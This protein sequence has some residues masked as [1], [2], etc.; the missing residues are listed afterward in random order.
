MLCISSSRIS[1]TAVL[2]LTATLAACSG[3]NSGNTDA[4]PVTVQSA[5]NAD[6]TP[7]N[8]LTISLAKVVGATQH[9]LAVDECEST[10][11]QNP[12]SA[13]SSEPQ[14]LSLDAPLSGAVGEGKSFAYRVPSGSQVVLS[15]A[16]GDANLYLFSAAEF[17]SETLLCRS[18]RL[19]AEE[20]CTAS[21]TDGEM[22]VLVYGQQASN[23]T[24]SATTD[25][26]VP[27]INRWLD[28]SMRDYYLFYD[29]VPVV[30][31]TGYD[32]AEQLISDLRVQSID[33]YT[34]VANASTQSQFFEEGIS[35]G[36]GYN[37]AIDSDRQA[38]VTQVQ[39]NAPFGLA[40]IKRGDIIESING[41]A[42]NRLDGARYR[43]LVGTDE[44]PL[45][46]TWVFIDG[47]EGHKKSLEL[48]K[49]RFRIE[50]VVHA[51]VLTN[52]EAGVKAGYLV[53]DSFLETSAVE[54]DQIMAYFKEQGITELI[55]DLRYNGGGRTNIARK[56]ASQIAGPLT[57]DKLFSEY[58]FNDKYQASN[59]SER[60]TPEVSALGLGRLI[61]LT[62]S[63]TASSSELVVNS[64]KPYIEVLTIGTRS[65]GKP[66]IS[67]SN[68]FCGKSL[69]A[70]EAQG[71]N[72]NGVGVLG[73]I[74]ADC[75][76][77][78]DLT[79]DFGIDD[80]S[81]TEGMLQAALDYI[82]SGRCDAPPA[83]LAKVQSANEG[84]LSIAQENRFGSAVEN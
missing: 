47:I 50:T 3:G 27:V 57:D 80:D 63:R 48:K 64:L 21:V 9:A 81:G 7:G 83:V 58:R 16:S 79:T 62:T 39:A 46:A 69:N 26:S 53:F 42:W 18:T 13:D 17:T 56:L 1:H 45:T 60:L 75:Y 5:G 78:D 77:T 44:N 37:W 2:F 54:L 67:S 66:F 51:Q 74:E 71:V 25:C 14:L 24:I 8:A 49:A 15:T 68:K 72:A 12:V 43:E 32:S 35:I 65:E 28:R 20:A 52:L 61:A 4:T 22:Y 76:A 23:Y 31:L 30:D 38:R 6:C 40:G 11:Q 33:P 10:G 82:T 55:L 73:G 59:F 41:Q 70:M 84:L 19:R 29:Q 34:S 36:L